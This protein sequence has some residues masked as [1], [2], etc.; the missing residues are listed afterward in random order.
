M[1][2]AAGRCVQRSDDR[3]ALDVEDE[4]AVDQNLEA[5]AGSCRLGHGSSGALER[6]Q[7]LGARLAVVTEPLP[8]L[9]G[10][11]GETRL[12]ASLAVDSP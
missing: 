10:H 5:A 1:A 3:A 11:H 7:R 4:L 9:E 12:L 2:G 8:L 6:G